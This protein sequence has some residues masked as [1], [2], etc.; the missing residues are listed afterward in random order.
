MSEFFFRLTRRVTFGCLVL[1]AVESASAQSHAQAV[2]ESSTDT[3]PVVNAQTNSAPLVHAQILFTGKLMGY[4]RIPDQQGFEMATCPNVQNSGGSSGVTEFLEELRKE[5]RYLTD[6]KLFPVLVGM[7]DNFAPEY[8]ARI[9]HEPQDRKSPANTNFDPGRPE[10]YFYT[11]DW[12]TDPKNPGW[13]LNETFENKIRMKD[14]IALELNHAINQ[15]M[16]RLVRT[17]SAVFESS[18]IRG[19]RPGKT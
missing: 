8:E 4:M 7:G 9:L 3:A 15:G 6:K 13:I 16:D 18:T 1:I 10:K 14:P 12:L 2:A 17:T 5:R 11:W 19:G